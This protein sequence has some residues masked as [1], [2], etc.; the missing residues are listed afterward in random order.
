MRVHMAYLWV[1][2]HV[3]RVHEAPIVLNAGQSM[4]AIEVNLGGNI[5]DYVGGLT[6]PSLNGFAAWGGQ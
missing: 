4:V 6:D 2:Q 5:K 1:L 3:S